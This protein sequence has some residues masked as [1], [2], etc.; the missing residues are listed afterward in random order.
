MQILNKLSAERASIGTVDPVIRTLNA[1]IKHGVLNGWLA[2]DAFGST[3]LR[4]EAYRK[5]RQLAVL[6][7]ENWDDVIT[8]QECPTPDAVEEA[9][10]F[11]LSYP[12]YGARFV[13]V[14][15]S[16]GLRLCEALALTVDDVD[17]ATG[18]VR[19]ERQLDRYGVWP[20]TKPP[21]GGRSRVTLF[22]AAYRQDW[23]SLVADA[24]AAGREH[25]FPLHRSKT[26]FADRVGVFANEAREAAGWAWSHHWLRHAYASY[27]LAPVSA[28]GYGLDLASVSQRLGHRKVSVTQDRYVERLPGADVLAFTATQRR[29][30][31]VR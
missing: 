22:W 5:A 29:P 26:K 17:L 19:V 4:R 25:L 18:K 23:E 15:F 10:A 3:A 27:S 21:K 6:S 31:R 24:R 28:G 20:D 8:L 9:A 16:S 11:E 12:G 2:E 1:V 13:R 30:G 7:A 14:C